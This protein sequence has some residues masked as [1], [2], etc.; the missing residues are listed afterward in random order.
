MTPFYIQN[1]PNNVMVMTM[2]IKLLEM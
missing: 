2:Y 1:S